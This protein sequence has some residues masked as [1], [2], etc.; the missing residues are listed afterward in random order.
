M[1]GSFRI[2][3][4]CDFCSI[5]GFFNGNGCQCL[6]GYLGNGKICREDPKFDNGL[7]ASVAAM[8]K[9]NGL[10]DL[11]VTGTVGVNNLSKEN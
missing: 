6:P 2:N 9:D 10:Q 8:V 11:N 5:N 7:S 3:G 1:S 4:V